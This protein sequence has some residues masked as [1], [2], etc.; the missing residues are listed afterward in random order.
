MSFQA[1]YTM[2]W[3]ASPPQGASHTQRRGHWLCA[4]ANWGPQE[5][6]PETERRDG[7][8]ATGS[9]VRPSPQVPAAQRPEVLNPGS[10]CT[11]T[12]LISGAR[13]GEGLGTLTPAEWEDGCPGDLLSQTPL[14]LR[15]STPKVVNG[16]GGGGLLSLLFILLSIFSLITFKENI[17]GAFKGQ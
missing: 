16:R 3:A 4:D 15:S 5:T 2:E 7:P 11:A 6:T 1:A 8:E 17:D 10:P 14:A 12:D 9:K 13:W